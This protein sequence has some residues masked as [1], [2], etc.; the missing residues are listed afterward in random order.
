VGDHLPLV[1]L[2]AGVLAAYLLVGLPLAGLLSR[3]ELQRRLTYEMGLRLTVYRQAI[4]RL[5]LLAGVAVALTG[6]ARV[7][8]AALGLRAPSMAADRLPVLVAATVLPIAA[9]TVVRSG[10][11][12]A[13]RTTG[14]LPVTQQERHLFAGVA[15]TAGAVEELLFRGFLMLYLHEALGLSLQLGAAASALA[16]G[17]SHLY[18]GAGTALAAGVIGYGFA[19]AYLITASLLVPVTVHILLDLRVLSTR[20]GRRPIRSAAV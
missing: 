13:S 3:R 11:G 9:A 4:G 12:S 15:L 16:F 5:W 6:W 1:T 18:Q 8:L 20:A 17:I 10:R 14:L 2:A 7:P 19:E